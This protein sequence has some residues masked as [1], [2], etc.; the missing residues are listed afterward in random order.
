MDS[1]LFIVERWGQHAIMPLYEALNYASVTGKRMDQSAAPPT[2][3][4]IDDDREVRVSI[5]ELLKA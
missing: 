1:V 3:F 2:V 5:A 4:V